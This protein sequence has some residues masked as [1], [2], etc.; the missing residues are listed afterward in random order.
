MTDKGTSRPFEQRFL[1]HPDTLVREEAIRLPKGRFGNLKKRYATLVLGASIAAAS[2]AIPMMKAS[3]FNTDQSG[4]LKAA[5]IT[6]ELLTGDLKAATKIAEEVTGGVK[7]ALGAPLASIE[8]P[9]TNIEDDLSLVTERVKE[10]F[11]KQEIPFGSMIYK[12]AMKNNLKPELVAAVVKTESRF[13]PNARSPVGARGLMQLMPRTGAWMGAKNLTDPA[14]NIQAGTKYLKY[15]NE[16]FDGN[17]TKVIAAYNA[18]EGNVRRFGGI[19][20]F[21]E[22]RNYVTKVRSS[23]AAYEEQIADRLAEASRD[24]ADELA[25][26]AT[27]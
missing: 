24:Q 13:K 10:E 4:P 5:G 1:N 6:E 15:L 25:D 22:T 9:I 20:P 8:A 3:R 7:Q 21:K 26:L 17:E 14:Q 18:G 2:L 16:R 11:F 12:E 27:R 19:P 23:T